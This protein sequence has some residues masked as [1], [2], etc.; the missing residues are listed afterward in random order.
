MAEIFEVQEYLKR[1]HD[2]GVRMAV[3]HR[4]MSCMARW[5]IADYFGLL[6]LEAALLQN[7]DFSKPLPDYTGVAIDLMTIFINNGIPPFADPDR[8]SGTVEGM[9][10]HSMIPMVQAALSRFLE[11]DSESVQALIEFYTPKGK[12]INEG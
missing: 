4:P 6:A 12:Q 2:V 3:M 10:V 1:V 9:Y 11:T 7:H 8:V 5:P